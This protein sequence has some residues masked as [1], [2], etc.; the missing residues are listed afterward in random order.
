MKCKLQDP[1]KGG[2]GTQP[3]L[4]TSMSSVAA[5][6]PPWWS[7]VQYSSPY[8]RF[9]FLWFL[10]TCGQPESETIKKGNSRNKQFPSFKFRA[11]LGSSGDTSCRSARAHVDVAQPFVRPPHAVDAASLPVAQWP[12]PLQDQPS[13]CHDSAGVQVTLVLLSN[14]HRV[15]HGTFYYHILV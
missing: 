2:L 15:I 5:F 9:R 10:L 13:Y 3:R 12:S 11:V 8:P 14:G 7:G 6:T 1:R 4:F